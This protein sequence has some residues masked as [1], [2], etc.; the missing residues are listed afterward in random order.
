MHFEQGQAIAVGVVTLG[1][2][3]KSQRLAVVGR[4]IA[5]RK[6]KTRQRLVGD[7]F[8]DGR[9]KRCIADEVRANR[10]DGQRTRGM[11]FIASI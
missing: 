5:G 1:A 7:V 8:A 10:M 3:S 6:V 9:R 4:W 11:A 2:E